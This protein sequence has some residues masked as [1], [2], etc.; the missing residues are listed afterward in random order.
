ELIKNKQTLILDVRTLGEY[1]QGHIKNSFLIPV[2]VLTTEHIKIMDHKDNPILIYCRS[3]NR[4]VTASNILTKNGFKK[5]YNLKGGIKDW[6]KNGLPIE[7][8]P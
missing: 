5:L 8:Q 7:K 1:T 3:G 6:I 4:S 2:Q